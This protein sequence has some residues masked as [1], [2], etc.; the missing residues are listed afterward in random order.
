[1]KFSEEKTL[2]RDTV[3]RMTEEHVA[4]IV[5]DLERT[6]RFPQEIADLFGDMG[7]LQLWI[8]ESYGGPGGDLT[9]VCIAKEE[10]ARGGCLAASTLC[11]NN[12]V[13]LILPLL[14]FGTEEQKWRYLTEAAKGRTIAAV[15]MTEPQAGSDVAS[16]RTTAKRDGSS[17]IIN[18][19]KNWI[20]WGAHAHY[21]LVFA[22][23]S[24]ER[25]H[26]GIS[27][28]L[29]DTKTPGYKVGQKE[30]KLG[31]HGAPTCSLFF[32]DMRVDADCM[33]GE[34]GKGFKA[35]MRI[36][37]LNRPTV[38]ASSLGM[39]Q[40]ALDLSTSYAKERIQFGRPIADL[41]A[42]Q[43]KLAAM[44]MRVEA[45]RALLYTSV[46]EIDSGDLSRLP[47][48]ASTCKCF[49]TDVAMEAALEAVQILGSYGYSK[50]YPAERLM[51]DA[52]LNQIL[53]GTNEI[54]HLIVA[55]RLLAS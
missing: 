20:T 14:H 51:R 12:S 49:I 45:S 5:A 40:A 46:A 39:A 8:P 38:A 7:L 16:I 18:G 43:F 10:I 42:I 50:E 32:D 33:I 24:G 11:A 2:F 52:K 48:L 34:E 21:T 15:A 17:Y 28:F 27:A 47:Y 4:P 23:T 54:H 44:A 29:V 13:G 53:E 1:M 30:E 35:C 41:Q 19:Q 25:G 31:R 3:R 55:R 6:D 26:D 36:M 22:R 37:D 9:T